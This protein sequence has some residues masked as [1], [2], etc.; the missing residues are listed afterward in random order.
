MTSKLTDFL[1]LVID[2]GKG[3]GKR[4]PMPELIHNFRLLHFFLE[5]VYCDW[6]RSIKPYQEKID[7]AHGKSQFN[8]PAAE[9]FIEIQPL[10]LKNIFSYC[11]FF[12]ATDLAYEK[13]YQQLNTANQ[14]TQTYIQHDKPPNKNRIIKNIRRVRNCSIVHMASDISDKLTSF[15]AINWQPLT[16]GKIANEKWD[17]NTMRFGSFRNIIRNNE[18]EVIEESEDIELPGFQ[19]THFESIKYLERFDDICS[20]YLNDLHAANKSQSSTPEPPLHPTVG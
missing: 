10:F 16:W 15:S 8:Y 18:G 20:I 9:A 11:M 1:P 6:M 2:A 3:S 5:E 14:I 13:V 12:V 7:E 4:L 17:L 19:K